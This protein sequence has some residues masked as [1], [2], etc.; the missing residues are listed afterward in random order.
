MSN[1]TEYTQNVQKHT[2]PLVWQGAFWKF[3][4]CACFAGI[5]GVVRYLTKMC[6]EGVLTSEPVIQLFQNLFG[7]LFLL[8]V[9][10]N[11]G[12]SNLKTKYP[13][14]HGI[15]VLMA[16]LGIMLWYKSLK[17]MPIAESL[18]LSFTGPIFTVIAAWLF[19]KE[20]LRLPRILAVILSLSGAFIIARPD[21]AFVNSQNLNLGFA[22]LFPIGSALAL[23]WNKLITRNLGSKGETPQALATYLLV[24]MAPVSLIPALYDW[25]TPMAHHWPWLALLGLLAALAHLSFGKAYALAE[26][27]FLTPFGFLKF[28]LSA[29]VGY[30]AFNE[31]PSNPALWLGLSIIGLSILL[32][33]YKGNYKIPLYSVA[34]RFKSN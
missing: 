2:I 32:I 17:H 22:V 5:N 18:A 25:Q 29:A 3:I 28:F 10:Y 15:R 11:F 31:F 33:N 14:L 30:F 27:T 16:V 19:L 9:I 34:K 4:S 20:S 6:P 26:V 7:V 23:A 12:L 13:L 8:P 21:L 1:T 24:F